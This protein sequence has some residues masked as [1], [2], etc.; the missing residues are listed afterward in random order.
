MIPIHIKR[1]ETDFELIK[2]YLLEIE[3]KEKNFICEIKF[4]SLNL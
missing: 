3:F 1:N 4:F 2:H